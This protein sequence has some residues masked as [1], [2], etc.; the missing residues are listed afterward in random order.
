MSHG[1]SRALLL[2]GAVEI[3]SRRY[4]VYLKYWTLNLRPLL[5]YLEVLYRRILVSGA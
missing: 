3:T 5:V 2:A 1:T 4:L